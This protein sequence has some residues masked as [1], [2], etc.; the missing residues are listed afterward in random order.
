MKKTIITIVSISVVVAILGTIVGAALAFLKPWQNDVYNK[1]NYEVSEFLSNLSVKQVVA[2]IGDQQLTNGRLQVFFWMQVYDMLN[3]LV[4]FECYAADEVYYE[5]KTT[6][7]LL[8][9]RPIEEAIIT[10]GGIDVREITPKTMESKV[11]P[12]LYLAGE[13]IDVDAYTGGYNLQIAFS[14][15]YLAGKSA[16]E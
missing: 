12:G 5:E 6:I 14:T 7:P 3:Y 11:C 10:R 1:D 13:I 15:G 8:D 9:F 2:T 4:D 16:A